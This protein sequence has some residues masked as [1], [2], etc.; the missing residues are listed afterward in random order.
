MIFPMQDIEMSHKDID[1][2]AE[3][4]WVGMR[5]LAS[6]LE[7]MPLQQEELLIAVASIDATYPT[8]HKGFLIPCI[9][10]FFHGPDE[11][12]Q[13]VTTRMLVLVVAQCLL[14]LVQLHHGCNVR[15]N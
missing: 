9:L 13:D 10:G 5:L 12:F 3:E 11:V 2:G 4:V 7:Q 14:D 6:T 8:V 1:M 15:L